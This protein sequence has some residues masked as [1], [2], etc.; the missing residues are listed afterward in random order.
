MAEQIEVRDIEE[1]ASLL[2]TGIE[3]IESWEKICDRE[4]ET[5]RLAIN[6]VEHRLRWGDID[7]LLSS[8]KDFLEGIDADLL[9]SER[10]LREVKDGVA[11]VESEHKALLMVQDEFEQMKNY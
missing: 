2:K 4:R 7:G 9:D 5:R 1:S 3:L 10:E 6:E 8:W 11:E